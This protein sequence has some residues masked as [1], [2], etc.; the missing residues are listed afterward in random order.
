MIEDLR[1]I[2]RQQQ[3][4]LPNNETVVEA[5]HTYP[6]AWSRHLGREGTETQT[7]RGSNTEE[8]QRTMDRRTT[9]DLISTYKYG[10]QDRHSGWCS[11]L[12]IYIAI[13]EVVGLADM[14]CLIGLIRGGHYGTQRGLLN[15]QR[16]HPQIH[17]L[18]SQHPHQLDHQLNQ[19]LRQV[20]RLDEDPKHQIERLHRLSV[21]KGQGRFVWT[22]TV[23]KGHETG[24]WEVVRTEIPTAHRQFALLRIHEAHEEIQD[25]GIIVCSS[26]QLEDRTDGAQL[27]GDMGLDAATEA[28]K[29]EGNHTEPQH[30]DGRARVALDLS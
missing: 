22:D 29:T 10:A 14:S 25:G 1:R 15:P 28:N 18:G 21:G 5:V 12:A 27:T 26:A 2:D 3:Y 16:E 7:A 24:Y 11:R 9:L 13:G 30:C 23:A 6:K 20:Q 19:K 17:P 8:R 4:N